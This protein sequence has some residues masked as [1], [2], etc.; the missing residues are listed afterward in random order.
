MDSSAQDSNGII[1]P[2]ADEAKARWGHAHAYKQSQERVGKMS[3]QQFAA[4]GQ[5]GDAI[6]RVVAALVEAGKQPQDPEVQEQIAKHYQWLRHFY[7]PSLEMYRGLGS[8]YADDPRF[9]ANFDKYRP[10]LT[11]FM[12]DA[13]HAYCD[14]Q[15]K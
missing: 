15:G 13:M 6:T 9:A 1:N 7:E 10:G 11:V 4:I 14:A 8:M 3:K 12:R 5:E 2:Y